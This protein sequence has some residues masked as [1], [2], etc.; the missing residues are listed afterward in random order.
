MLHKIFLVFLVSIFVMPYTT[1]G[2][3]PDVYTDKNYQASTHE[4]PTD[5]QRTLPLVVYLHKTKF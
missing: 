3:V 1:H 4:Q 2:A 5:F